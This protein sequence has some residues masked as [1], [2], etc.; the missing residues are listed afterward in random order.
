MDSDLESFATHF[1]L[2]PPSLAEYRQVVHG[3]VN[4]LRAR[5]E[6]T[7]ELA[8]AETGELYEHLRGLS[9][10]ETRRIVARGIVRDGKLST[11]DIDEIREAKREILERTGVLS[12]V[13]RPSDLAHVAGL[14]AFK[15]WIRK[16]TRAFQEPEAAKAFGLSPARGVL[17]IGVQGCGKSLAAKAVA[18]EWKL[19]IVR[20]DPANLFSKYIGETEKALRRALATVEAMAPLVVWIDELEKAFASSR[21]NDGGV[22]ARLMGSLLAWL[23]EHRARVFVVA[24][25]NDIAALP[26]ELMRKGRFDEIF[27]VDLP[28]ASA[29]AELLRIHLAARGRILDEE[30]L[31][32]VVAETEGF[33]GAEVQQ[34]VLAALH[35][36]FSAGEEL[37]STHLLSELRGTTPM[38]VTMAERIG[39]LRAWADRR[40]VRADG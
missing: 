13:A 32:R 28:D 35:A 17:L 37:C 40:A 31:A 3:V 34:P 4:E 30:T 23:Q 8:E 20:L 10:A 19:P 33:S 9:L 18:G 25:A 27:F 12:H 39:E 26:H 5:R 15:E 11:A 22:T 38:S 7:I 16:R 2:E 24:T 14:S 1:R 36:A 21:E 29:R 6:V